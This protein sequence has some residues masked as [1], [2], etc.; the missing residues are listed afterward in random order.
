V[1]TG[2]VTWTSSAPEVAR[3]ATR[4][5]VTAESPGSAILS[6]QLGSISGD[7]SIL[8]ESSQLTSI[9]I[10]P[11]AA[12]IRQQAQ[13]TFQAI[14]TFADGNTQD[15]TTSVLWTSSPASVATI[16]IGRATG[17]APGT[18]I[19]VAFFNGQVGT[20]T[21]TVTRATF[22]TPPAAIADTE[23]PTIH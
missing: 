13:I 18:G 11:P 4:G 7:S 6:A 23:T 19:I 17:V 10:S 9:Q 20:A 21:L 8:V 15:L 22:T 2:L 5:R 16:S 12:S 14:G 3:V 1:I